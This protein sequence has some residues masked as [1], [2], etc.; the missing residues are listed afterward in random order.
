MKK[1]LLNY[2]VGTYPF[3]VL[4]TIVLALLHAL[5]EGTGF[6]LLLPIIEGLSSP[7]TIESTHP[8]SIVLR[9]IFE[10]LGLSFTLNVLFVV[11]ISLFFLQAILEY[12]RVILASTITE[13]FEID[14]RVRLFE[15]LL[16]ASLEYFHRKKLGDIVNGIVLEAHRSAFAF[17]HLLGTMISGSLV[18][19]YFAVSLLVSWKLTLL[20][21]VIALPLVYFT[22]GRR[23]IVKKG[24]EITQ[25]NENFQSATV[26]FLQGVRE[27]KIYG[28]AGEISK[29]F[30]RTATDAS[31]QEKL[32]NMLNARY[33]FVYQVIA[34]AFLFLLGGIGTFVLQVS[35]AEMATL[36]A[37]LMR[38]SPGV[39]QLQKS[40]DN[41][42]GLLSGFE[43]T[44]KMIKEVDESLLEKGDREEAVAIKSLNSGIEVIDGNFAYD[45]Q[46]EVLRD[47]NIC[48]DRGKTSA[49]VGA[50]GAGKS[51]LVDLVV[52]FYD[53]TKGQILV[54]GENLKNIDIS[55][56]RD[57][58]GFVSQEAF[59]FN[60]SIFRNIQ[61]G[62][63]QS[64]QRDVIYAAQRANAHEFI[65]ALPDGYDT[66]IGDR[67]VKL[68]GGQRQRLALARA[69]LR[70]PPILILDEAT[71]D[72]DSKSERLIQDALEEI[73]QDRTVIVI[74]HRLSTI[75][76]AD[77]IIVLDEGQI[78]ERG[79]HHSLLA[80]QG[81]YAEFY[82]IQF[83]DN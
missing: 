21:I 80:R 26:E 34:V 63:L 8:V 22:R 79:S 3:Y 36:L 4:A 28:L 33:A 70:N 47:I 77:E 1:R 55:S 32:L 27:I 67:G 15:K 2:A 69:I 76:R 42:L 65:E 61:Y 83:S 60:D 43:A 20:T 41:Y 10:Y 39:T 78:V 59:L 45:G 31:R 62:N 72:L 6:S 18:S 75:E 71:S 64:T 37:I 49:I 12:L 66:I 68:S 81:E 58:I 82:N 44:Q 11:G 19:V 16:N 56:W 17:H 51:T 30:G 23:R 52:R 35:T 57:L 13:R 50:S 14:L 7:G 74:A 48:F 38:L 25:A 24:Q 54:D 5:V 53:P 73:S 46:S 40:R 29:I 9:D